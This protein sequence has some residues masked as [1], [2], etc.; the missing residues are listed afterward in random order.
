MA[1]AVTVTGTF[2]PGKSA[3]LQWQL[4]GSLFDSAG[5]LVY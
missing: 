5:G 3:N 2:T 4:S 1:T